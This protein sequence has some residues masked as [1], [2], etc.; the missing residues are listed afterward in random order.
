MESLT[1]KAG[2]SAEPIVH[3]IDDDKEIRES[4][5]DLFMITNR[6]ASAYSSGPDFLKTVDTTAPGCVVVD[7][8]MPE[9]SGLDVQSELIT[10]GSRMPVIFLTGHADVRASV[11]AM[12][13][14][15][16]DFIMK[17]FVNR[18]LLDAVDLAIQLDGERRKIEAEQ[19]HVRSLVDTL[20]PREH[21]VM[22]AVVSGLMNKQIAFE[23]GI[24]EMT[25]KLHRMSVMR[26]MQARSLADLVRKVEKLQI[27]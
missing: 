24:S 17:P 11:R 9:G 19:A 20:T 16:T 22:L 3:V 14:G 7:L 15:A 12:K 13:A 8:R 10:M 26:K 21:E 25:V 23:L 1:T 4:L 2:L 6:R 27:R 18:D 5:L